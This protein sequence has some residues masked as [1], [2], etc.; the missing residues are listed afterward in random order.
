MKVLENIS[1]II[2]KHSQL[3]E[4]KYS[5]EYVTSEVV[6]IIRELLPLRDQKEATRCYHEDNL[7]HDKRVRRFVEYNAEKQ[8]NGSTLTSTEYM[9]NRLEC[10]ISESILHPILIEIIEP[11]RYSF[12]YLYWLLCSEYNRAVG[13]AFFDD[14]VVSDAVVNYAIKFDIDELKNSDLDIID[15]LD[16]IDFLLL[17]SKNYEFDNL[18]PILKKLK[19]RFESYANDYKSYLE[20]KLIRIANGSYPT[21]AGQIREIPL[22]KNSI[23][24]EEDPPE[25]YLCYFDFTDCPINLAI[26][27][28]QIHLGRYSITRTKRGLDDANS[29]FLDIISNELRLIWET[30]IIDVPKLF[31]STRELLNTLFNSFIKQCEKI[32]YYDYEKLTTF[33]KW[34]AINANGCID[35]SYFI[36]F[37]DD[38]Y[39]PT[40]PNSIPNYATEKW[41]KCNFF[42]KTA[43]EHC[44]F[45]TISYIKQMR[46]FP[47]KQMFDIVPFNFY[48]EDF[49]SVQTNARNKRVRDEDDRIALN[50]MSNYK[51]FNTFLKQQ[52]SRLNG[53]N[54]NTSESTSIRKSIISEII[55]M[56]N[57]YI[58]RIER[59]GIVDFEALQ[60]CFSLWK[61]LVCQIID[62]IVRQPILDNEVNK[63]DKSD[64]NAYIYYLKTALQYDSFRK[65]FNQNIVDAERDYLTELSKNKQPTNKEL[66]VDTPNVNDPYNEKLKLFS[67][68]VS[69][70]IDAKALFDYLTDRVTTTKIKGVKAF[71]YFDAAVRLKY[72]L[73]FTYRLAT[74]CFGNIGSV[75]NFNK[76]VGKNAKFD[77]DIV[78]IQNEMQE[79][80]EKTTGRQNQ[81]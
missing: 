77:T 7:C 10:N 60:Y 13:F 27:P 54:L 49:T 37:H 28:F 75:S 43:K 41:E 1:T 16:K 61:W 29:I 78:S 72:I 34:W 44:I 76:Y 58:C 48:K 74:E 9:P 22:I 62:I 79:V 56:F 12:G 59:N 24:Y 51:H 35:T 33:A 17:E 39:D 67:S 70:R 40:D 55:G 66:C 63:K 21:H 42:V 80:V 73:K 3:F 68:S 31:D 4:P 6:R 15:S 46:C 8:L 23:G 2:E 53:L 50:F 81:N 26:Y 20:K 32:C 5:K 30:N 38:D 69:T 36:R 64:V 47:F 71:A 57:D 65:A 14:I 25:H 52:L 19:A 18:D 45:L 11:D